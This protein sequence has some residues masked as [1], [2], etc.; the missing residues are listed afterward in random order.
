MTNKPVVSVIASAIYTQYWLNFH[1]AL[2]ATNKTSFEIIFV[3]NTR[4][5]F[6]LPEGFHYIYSELDVVACIEIAYRHSIG[7]FILGVADDTRFSPG[8]IDSL[9]KWHKRLRSKKVVVGSRGA[10]TPPKSPLIPPPDYEIPPDQLTYNDGN[11]AILKREM[12][13]IMYYSPLIS[14]E[15]WEDV[16]GLEKRFIAIK[17]AIDMQLRFYEKGYLPFVAFDTYTWE[18]RFSDKRGRLCKRKGKRKTVS[19]DGQLLNKMWIEDN[20]V[21]PARRTSG[22]QKF[23]KELK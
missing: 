17:W 7:D 2:L 1:A 18:V 16:G 22:V 21:Q 5:D 4:P 20:E 12:S 10:N 11:W 8:Y 9:Y 19:G 6:E 3:G 14:R 15:A 23:P 13:P